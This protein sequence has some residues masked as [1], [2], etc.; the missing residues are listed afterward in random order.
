MIRRQN[1][2]CGVVA[3]AAFGVVLCCGTGSGA[4]QE[5][6]MTEAE[7]KECLAKFHIEPKRDD[8][9][10]PAVTPPKNCTFGEK[11]GFP[12]PDP[13]CT[14][15]AVNPTLTLK[16]LADPGFKTECVRDDATSEDEKKQTYAAY[17]MTEPAKNSGESQTC[18]LDH[19]ISLELGGADTLDNIWPQC[20]PDN[21]GL[22]D[23]NF[24]RKDLVEDFLGREVREGRLSMA[25]AQKGIVEDWTQFL[26]KAKDAC[27]GAKC[28]K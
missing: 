4:A 20:G 17:N 7:K 26:D 11:N 13:K 15:G 5:R 12:V 25:D 1:S 10:H 19:F 14:P 27:T 28:K 9:M 22:D 3:V 18:E 6:Q 16:V 8:P 23:R 24:K 21:V 2:K